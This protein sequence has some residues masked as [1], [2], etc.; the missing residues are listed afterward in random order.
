MRSLS[1]LKCFTLRPVIA[2][3]SQIIF[4]FEMFIFL[5][6]ASRLTTRSPEGQARQLSN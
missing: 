5:E 2:D 1:P 6:A 4:P 3:I